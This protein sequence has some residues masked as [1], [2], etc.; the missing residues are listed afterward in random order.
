MKRFCCCLLL[1]HS[2][3]LEHQN[4]PNSI[5]YPWHVMKDVQLDAND[6]KGARKLYGIKKK[7][8]LL[9]TDCDSLYI[10]S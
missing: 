5:M 7:N 8:C 4:D 1:G 9:F 3:G 2:L 6:I 10:F